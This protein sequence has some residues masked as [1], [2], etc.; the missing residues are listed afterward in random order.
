MQQKCK[1]ELL[2][3]ESEPMP[4]LTQESETDQCEFLA[5]QHP[6]NFPTLQILAPCYFGR[7]AK[8]LLGLRNQLESTLVKLM[9]INLCLKS[10]GGIRY[11]GDD[12]KPNPFL[13]SLLKISTKQGRQ[14]TMQHYNPKRCLMNQKRVRWKKLH[15]IKQEVCMSRL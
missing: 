10:N 11:A 4:S 14:R 5:Q 15:H 1:E 9:I 8:T 13:G 3:W 6:G 12:I 7:N 2:L